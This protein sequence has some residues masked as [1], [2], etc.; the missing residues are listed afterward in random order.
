MYK[1]L[2]AEGCPK[3][4]MIEKTKKEIERN[5]Y[6]PV[7]L[8][9]QITDLF[10]GMRDLNEDEAQK[11]LS[12][13]KDFRIKEA[14][15]LFIYYA[16][17]RKNHFKEKG[18]FK[19]DKFKQQLEDVCKSE[20]DQLKHE[21]SFTI[22]RHI[23]NKTEKDESQPDFKFFENIKS[24]WV[25]L[26]ENIDKNM[27]FPLMRTLPFVLK[28]KS[29]YSSYK[30]YFFQLIETMLQ[31]YE[32]PNDYFIHLDNILPA[33]SENNPDDLVKILFLFLNKG[34]PI[35]GIIPFNYEV[36]ERLIPEIKKEKTRISPV[37]IEKAEE[38]LK[39]YHETLD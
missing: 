16:L 21:L 2:P 3:F 11:F 20:P 13:V 35:K 12:F 30:K 14:D 39:K 31:I 5:K 36:R 6:N 1:Q 8:F 28:N 23:E 9:S 25:L 27:I 4:I 26:F 19:S 7:E 18:I 17:Y 32:H 37:S 24:Y 22:C 15:H 38:E 10:N 29:Y 34:D 33:I